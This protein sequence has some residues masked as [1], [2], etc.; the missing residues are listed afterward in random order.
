MVKHA[1]FTDEATPAELCEPN[2]VVAEDTSMDFNLAVLDQIKSIGRIALSKQ[3]RSCVEWEW[4]C[5]KL[6]NR[7]RARIEIGEERNLSQ[8]VVETTFLRRGTRL[9]PQRFIGDRLCQRRQAS[10]QGSHRR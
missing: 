1:H 5:G 4:P 3:H 2:H 10:H 8:E 6:E 7:E 9:E